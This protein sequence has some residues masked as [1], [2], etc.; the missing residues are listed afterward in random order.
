[1]SP[2]KSKKAGKKAKEETVKAEEAAKAAEAAKVTEADHFAMEE[3]KKQASQSEPA[4][5]AQP[6]N[7]TAP[8]MICPHFERY[9]G[10]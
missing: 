3:A 1:V 8:G 6:E 4:Q 9:S 7:G 5:V 10:R 2:I